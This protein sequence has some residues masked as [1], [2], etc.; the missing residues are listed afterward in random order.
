VNRLSVHQS[1]LHP[2]SPVQTIDLARAAGWDSVGFHIGAVEETEPWWSGGP[3][4]RLLA[5]TI[6]R[7]LETR[8]SVLDVGRVVLTVPEEPAAVQRLHDHVLDFGARLGAQFVT[9][10][11]SGAGRPGADGVAERATRFATFADAARPYRLR[12][13][14]SAVPVD[15]PDL[16]PAAAA[17]V[18]L[19]GGG[20]VLDV[21][22]HCSSADL[23]SEA[24]AELWE[25]LGY[26]RVDARALER[27]GEAAAGQLAVVPPHVPVVIGGDDGLGLLD[28][29]PEGRLIRLRTLVD[30]MLEHPRARAVRAARPPF[31]T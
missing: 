4:Q 14:L 22:V 27:D 5:A 3:G 23:V 8:V 19:C 16:F 17:V 18:E 29:D 10:R 20:L 1:L 2:R 7:L 26:V 15:R 28:R 12:P 30:R 31:D 25:Y 11:F 13:L 21:P 24:V 9:V 6:D